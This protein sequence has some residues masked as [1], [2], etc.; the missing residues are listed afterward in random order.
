[1]ALFDHS[2]VALD[3]FMGLVPLSNLGPPGHTFPTDHIYFHINRLDPNNWYAGTVTAPVFTP[4]DVWVT[5]VTSRRRCRTTR[6]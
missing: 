6:R 2:P 1:M 3:D 4:G 5:E